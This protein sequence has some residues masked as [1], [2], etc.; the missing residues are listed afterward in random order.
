MFNKNIKLFFRSIGLYH[1]CINICCSKREITT[2]EESDLLTLLSSIHTIQP[3]KT[4][5]LDKQIFEHIDHYDFEN[6]NC[7]NSE[8]VR[9][10]FIHGMNKVLS[11]L[12]TQCDA[13]TELSKR[14][15]NLL[16]Y[17]SN[18]TPL[19]ME[20]FNANEQVVMKILR[21]YT[22]QISSILSFVVPKTKENILHVFLK[23]GM[24]TAVMV[25]ME[26]YEV[27]DLLF[28][29]NI[30]GDIPLS[31]AIGQH[32]IEGENV[33]FTDVA[34]AIWDNMLQ[35]RRNSETN[36]ALTEIN[37]KRK[38]I[39]HT[40]S[41]NGMNTLLT[42]ICLESGM[43]KG[44]IENALN[45]PNADG[46]TPLDG[47]KDEQTVL[48][49]MDAELKLDTNRT[50]VR[51]NNVLHM[52]AK[53]N[54]QICLRK[55][56]ESMPNE[57]R[58]REILL[59][60]NINGNNPLMSCIFKNSDGSLNYLLGILLTMHPNDENQKLIKKILH[61]QNTKGDTLLG[62]ILHYQQGTMLSQS[63]AL[64][65]EKS[66]HT[67]IENKSQ[68]M[69]DLTKCLRQHVHPSVEVLNAIKNVEDS[70]EKSTFQK[71]LILIKLFWSSFL[72]PLAIMISDMS[73]DMILLLGYACYLF[74]ADDRI[75]L[76]NAIDLC[77]MM[78]HLP[79]STVCES[80]F[81]KNIPNKLN[82]KPRFFYSLAFITL[83]WLF[84]GF[85]FCHSRHWTN[86][87][88]KVSIYA[89]IIKNIQCKFLLYLSHESFILILF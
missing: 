49:I 13:G 42:K 78:S 50:D 44:I 39:L 75:C 69:K 88:R 63:I 26:H 53:K 67:L 86:T 83:P 15:G 61:E 24:K 30:A 45:Q 34:A 57:K 21:M 1:K 27:T 60:K 28:T 84:Y 4:N 55:I 65:L 11:K 58:T 18:E 31:L 25:L 46:L 85:E 51:G 81:L 29:P 22:E 19:L 7:F 40:C 82:G 41:D 20:H 35:S 66:C 3:G 33:V 79:N 59:H 12:L 64:D 16:K 48:K 77:P 17:D 8:E 89:N 36:T 38:N 56:M 43:D 80:G 68:T 14:W 62:L 87:T 5:V 73:F 32:S 6:W 76:T 71:V 54:F 47:C 9:L 52:Y 70:Y 10:C 37:S 72:M 23:R 74:M 2:T